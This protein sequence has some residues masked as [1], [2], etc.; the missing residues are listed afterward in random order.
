MQSTQIQRL[1]KV[2]SVFSLL[3]DRVSVSAHFKLHRKQ[4]SLPSAMCSPV[5]VGLFT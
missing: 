1:D 2:S 3:H 5:D 4:I